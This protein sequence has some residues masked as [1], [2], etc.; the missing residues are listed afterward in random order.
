MLQAAAAAA[1]AAGTRLPICRLR[2]LNRIPLARGLGSSSAAIV[3]GVVA[4]NELLGLGLSE[5]E[6]LTIAARVEGHPD[7]VAPALLGGLT[8]CCLTG[9]GVMAKRLDVAAGLGCVVAVPD[10]E[11]S[12]QAAR[13]ALPETVPHADAV[14]NLCRASLAVAALVT[15]DFAL[16]GEATR[17]RLHQPYRAPLVPGLQDAIEA[18]LGAGAVGACLSGSG[19]TVVAFITQRGEEVG[20]AMVNALRDAGANARAEQL[21]LA[22]EGARVTDRATDIEHDA[23]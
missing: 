9:D 22:P 5:R 11:V 8:V 4:A 21:S 13:R 10:Y 2:Q 7:N 23:R 19:P 18:A 20:A 1:E 12:T 14:F 16:L 15:G 3:A 6:M 17:D